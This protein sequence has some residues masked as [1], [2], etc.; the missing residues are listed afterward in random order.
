[1][2]RSGP[3]SICRGFFLAGLFVLWLLHGGTAWGTDPGIQGIINQI[4]DLKTTG[5]IYEAAVA[6]DLNSML[7]TIDLVITEGDKF[8]AQTL[9]SAFVNVVSQLQGKLMS[10]KAASDLIDSANSLSLS[11]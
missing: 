7:T 10:L 11:L 3:R 8:T 6:D 2:K 5:E 9:L 4:A 1:M